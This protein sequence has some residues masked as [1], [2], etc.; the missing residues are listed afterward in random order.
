MDKRT[1]AFYIAQLGSLAQL[2]MDVPIGRQTG[3]LVIDDPEQETMAAIA[4]A[5]SL[6]FA[7][8][9]QMRTTILVGCHSNVFQGLTKASS[10]FSLLPLANG[11][12]NQF[13]VNL[14][15]AGGKSKAAKFAAKKRLQKEVMYFVH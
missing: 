5:D 2:A 1:A 13:M 8:V 15:E 14:P 11:K 12:L 4:L 6:L 10:E 7:T 9:E 3:E